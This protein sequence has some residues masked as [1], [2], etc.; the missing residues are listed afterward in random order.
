MWTLNRTRRRETGER[1][2]AAIIMVGVIVL[3]VGFAA[4]AV[5]LGVQRVAARDMQAI[6]DTAALDAARSLPTCDSAVLT[7]AANR[8]RAR[9]GTVIGNDAPLVAVPGHLDPTTKEFR[10]GARNGQCDAVQVTARTTVSHTFTAG[11]GSGTRSA[12]GTQAQSSACFSVGTRTLTLNT[13]ES[14]LGPLLDSILKVNLSVIGYDGLVGL[15]DISVPL[16]D[17]SVAL[18]VGTPDALV[19]LDK[20]S[21]GNFLI[22]S[23]RVLTSNGKIAEAQVLQAIAVQVGGF[24]LNVGD[25]LKVGIGGSVG[26]GVEVNIFDLVGA[27]IIAANGR[28]ALRVDGLGITLPGLVNVRTG[29]VIVEPPQIA[30]G[31][32]GTVAKSAQVR[33]DLAAGINALG[34]AAADLSLGF[35]IGSG[36]AALSAVSCATGNPQV[37]FSPINTATIALTGAG[38]AGAAGIKISVLPA[39][40]A[41]ALTGLLRLILAPLGLTL[42]IEV[43]LGLSVGGAISATRTL[44]YPT[45][46]KDVVSGNTLVNLNTTTIRLGQEGFLAGLL[47]ALLNPLLSTLTTGIVQPIV[48]AVGSLAGGIIFPALGLLGLKAG[49]AEINL[50]GKPSCGGVRL[51]G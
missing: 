24:D 4:F 35:K 42:S 27:A 32:V 6:A 51:A 44:T 3:S 5:D 47:G 14:V 39:Q 41:N 34:V 33:F 50:I 26:L 21:L 48:N 36:S 16:I 10:T 2:A 15:K 25:I 30:C 28:N 13:S 29:L 20:I 17:L 1:G 9:H 8:N 12:V 38:E 45:K 11:A 37:T 31:P 19:S 40:Y 23:A 22:A 18:G 43:G 7:A 49:V 46:T